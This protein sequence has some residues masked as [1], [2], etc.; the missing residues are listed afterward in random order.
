[1][2]IAAL[3]PLGTALEKTGGVDFMAKTLIDTLGSLSALALMAGIF[4]LVC[5]FS[6]ISNNVVS[7]ILISPVAYQTPWQWMFRFI[8][9]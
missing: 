3:I 8:P 1:M 2:L 7:A 4:L 6:Q 9:S 5:G